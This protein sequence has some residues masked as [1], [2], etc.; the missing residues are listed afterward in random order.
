M[1]YFSDPLKLAA[2]KRP[3]GRKKTVAG[4]SAVS[5]ELKII[6]RE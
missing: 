2:P 1:D 5:E 6:M 4:S 3:Q